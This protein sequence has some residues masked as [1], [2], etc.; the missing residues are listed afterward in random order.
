MP[1][2]AKATP[3]VGHRVSVKT[4]GVRGA[5]GVDKTIG[6]RLRG[7]RLEANC[8]QSELADAL[9]VSFQQVQKYEKG[10]NRIGAARLVEIARTLQVDTSYFLDDLR[11]VNGNGKELATTSRFAE[12]LATTD[13]VKINDAMLQLSDAHRHEVIELARTLVR[14]YAK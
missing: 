12:F 11:P 1:R 14:A 7:L 3:K 10:V 8:S 6:I 2:K 13:G 9:G 5:T 4:P